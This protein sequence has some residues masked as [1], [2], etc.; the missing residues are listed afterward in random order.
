M[1]QGEYFSV[2]RTRVLLADDFQPLVDS[3][4][5]LLADEFEII[6]SVNDGQ[7]AVEAIRRLDPDLL[8]LD[9]AMPNLNGFEVVAQLD[10]ARCRTK[11]ILLTS[12]RDPELISAGLA[13]GVVGYVFKDRMCTDLPSAIR[14]V[15]QGQTFVSPSHQL[16]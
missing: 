1:P 4:R 14:D 13:A 11:V 10:L 6:D 16:R 12:Y 3:V 8:V 9:I 7:A 2:Q 5:R 15:M